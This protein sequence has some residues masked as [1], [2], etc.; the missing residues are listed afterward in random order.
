MVYGSDRSR[1]TDMHL[2]GMVQ[3]ICHIFWCPKNNR[4]IYMVN[5][6]YISS[7]F[8]LS[9]KRAVEDKSIGPLVKM[10]M[11]RCIQCTRCIRFAS[12]VAGVEALGTTGR[13]NDTQV[14]T[15]VEKVRV[16]VS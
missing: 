2:V 8:G 7:L 11:T 6:L 10:T 14:G 5:H 9:G 1:F 12:E 13:G 15:Y 3:E 4:K 16:I